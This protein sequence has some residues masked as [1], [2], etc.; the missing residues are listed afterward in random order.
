MSLKYIVQNMGGG[1]GDLPTVIPYFL[2]PY[3]TWQNAIFSTLGLITP[4]LTWQGINIKQALLVKPSPLVAQIPRVG[5]LCFG[6]KA[7]LN[8]MFLLE[9]LGKNICAD[10]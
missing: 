8:N 5:S 6:A 1:G 2:S 4:G 3:I 9:R 7:S 10:G